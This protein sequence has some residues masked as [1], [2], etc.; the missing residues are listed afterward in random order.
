MWRFSATLQLAACLALLG[1]ANPSAAQEDPGLLDEIVVTATRMESSVGDV[2]R[3]ISMIDK[4]RIQNATQQ[5]GLGEAL[6]GVPGLYIQNRY[7]FSQD[8]SISLRGFGA[9]ASFGIRGIR[10]YVDGIPE[11]LP[12]GQAQVDSI[13]LGSADSIEVLRGPASSLYGNASGG[14][15]A[16]ETELGAA[17]PY[18]EAGAAAG[19]MG[20]EQYGVKSGGSWQTLDYLL[21]V[22]SQEI[23]GYR[24]HSSAKGSLLNG[25]VGVR[26]GDDDQ[27]TI[28]VN[29]TDQPNAQDPGAVDAAQAAANPRA[30]RDPNVLFDSGE[31][32]SQQR[33]GLVYE[34]DRPAGSLLL[35]NY[36]VWRDF[37]NRLPFVDGGAVQFDRFFYGAG[38]QYSFGEQ[39]PEAAGITVGIDFDRQVDDRRRFDNNQGVPG[40]LVFDQR[41]RVDS[42]GAY[43]LGQYEL[44]DRWN[45]SASLRYDEVSFDVGDRFLA[46]GDDAGEIGF[47]Q[48][49]PSLGASFHFGEHVVFGSFSSS[50]E[51]PTTTELA[52][53]DGSGGFNTGLAPQ[54]ADNYEIGI[55]G[56]PA[57]LYY[58]LALFHIELT[59]ELVPFEI[60]GFPGRTFFANAGESTRNG[61]ETALAWQHD[62]GFGAEASWTW[63]DFEFDS[64]TD[65]SG[66]QFGGKQLP[67]L[68]GHFGYVGLTYATAG[69]FYA[70][71]EARYSGQLYADSANTVEV[72]RYTVANLRAS[73]EIEHGDWIVQPYFGV[74]NLL[75][76]RYNSHI[77]TN[78]FGGRYYE[79]A[80][81]RNAY[82]GIDV[83]YRFGSL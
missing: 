49:S 23:D 1:V 55:K 36:Y 67:G 38:I 26:L 37:E 10:V 57:G 5:L 45:L 20:F 83:R 47:D 29:H 41:E 15:I 70:R 22:S 16:I 19:E 34:R 71:L 80:P 50:F 79:P 61:L 76:E 54:R 52:N 58:E 7:N 17:E 62:S 64:F 40:D 73:H 27:L 65:E 24:E 68:P 56:E 72:G 2:A 31:S 21:N 12:D 18:L 53:P 6:A 75:D 74:N 28:A 63:S 60:A 30:A 82:F 77:R 33:L 59:D 9:R 51:T 32:L 8:L 43:V 44:G 78:A 11:T 69:G 66:N 46:D 35:R 4:E 25:K 48:V 3:S 39:L 42:L 13:D 14:V 81:E